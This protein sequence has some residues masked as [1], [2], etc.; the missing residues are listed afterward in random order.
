LLDS[1]LQETR[2]SSSPPVDTLKSRP[3]MS[4]IMFENKLSSMLLNEVEAGPGLGGQDE[5]TSTSNNC[6]DAGPLQG[7]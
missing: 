2:L 6:S 3:K 5:F 1:L 4:E 7:V